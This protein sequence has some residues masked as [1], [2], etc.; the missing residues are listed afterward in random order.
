MVNSGLEV[1]IGSMT[2]HVIIGKS[3]TKLVQSLLKCWTCLS[4]MR[5][6]T[7]LF[8]P[9]HSSCPRGGNKPCY[10]SSSNRAQATQRVDGVLDPLRQLPCLEMNLYQDA[11]RDIKIGVDGYTLG[12]SHKRLDWSKGLLQP[13]PWH[14]NYLHINIFILI[15]HDLCNPKTTG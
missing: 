14:V 8:N 15:T 12:T 5:R 2:V 7:V 3:L 11:A 9:E 1:G 10:N 4:V 6:H 13:L